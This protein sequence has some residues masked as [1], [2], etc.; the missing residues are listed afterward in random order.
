MRERAGEPV[1]RRAFIGGSGAAS[2]PRAYRLCLGESSLLARLSGQCSGPSVR[3]RTADARLLSAVRRTER[4]R[5]ARLHSRAPARRRGGAKGA[6]HCATSQDRLRSAGTAACSSAVPRA[7]SEAR[8]ATLSEHLARSRLRR[9]PRGVAASASAPAALANAVSSAEEESRA[10]ANPPTGVDEFACALALNDEDLVSALA[11]VAHQE[12]RARQEPVLCTAKQGSP[13]AL[14]ID[15]EMW[16]EAQPP[17]KKPCRDVDQQVAPLRHANTTSALQ[18]HVLA[19][20]QEQIRRRTLR[21][22][23]KIDPSQS[24][25]PW[26]LRRRGKSPMASTAQAA[27]PARNALQQLSLCF[28]GGQLRFAF[29]ESAHDRRM[30][31]SELA[32]A[33]RVTIPKPIPL[34][35]ARAI[36]PFSLPA[37]ST[38]ELCGKFVPLAHVA[39]LAFLGQFLAVVL[40][41]PWDAAGHLTPRGLVERLVLGRDWFARGLLCVWV[42]KRHLAELVEAAEKHWACK[43]VENIAWVVLDVANRIDAHETCLMFRR[44]PGSELDLR[45][46]RNADVFFACR[47]PLD[48]VPLRPCFCPN[49][50]CARPCVRIEPKPDRLLDILETLLPDLAA[51]SASGDGELGKAATSSNPAGLY[52][53]GEPDRKRPSWTFVA[54]LE[55][56]RCVQEQRPDG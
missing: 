39:E 36:E 27:G 1:S 21:Q 29:E 56:E 41:P 42:P 49:M 7:M 43:Y 47:Q 8:A 34:A 38:S 6:S 52:V 3:E 23:R 17:T 45:H 15:V 16:M 54:A 22:R 44:C 46:Q 51:A 4:R 40:D 9:A 12:Q 32:F 35:W 50:A 28:Q 2:A 31:R 11:A 48:G 37:S 26:A 53:W 18:P 55:P 14:E 30:R 13:W 10:Q 33:R 25:A 5:A 20:Q 19:W 24:T